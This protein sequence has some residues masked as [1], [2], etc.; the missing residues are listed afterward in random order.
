MFD[1]HLQT[2]DFSTKKMAQ[3]SKRSPK[4]SLSYHFG[5]HFVSFILKKEDFSCWPYNSVSITQILG[6]NSQWELSA[7]SQ[8][9]SFLESM[10]CLGSAYTA[11]VMNSDNQQQLKKNPS[12][13]MDLKQSHIF[14]RQPEDHN[15]VQC[16]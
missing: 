13:A 15:A 7:L 4:P 12:R 1:L 6:C 11:C 2:N 8:Q 5:N 10:R 3:R 16:I 14:A 9:I